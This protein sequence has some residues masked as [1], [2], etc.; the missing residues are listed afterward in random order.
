[1]SQDKALDG[2]FTALQ[3]RHGKAIS[4][5]KE[6]EAV[7][8]GDYVSEIVPEKWAD[9]GLEPTVMPTASDIIHNAVDHILTSPR[10]KV[11]MRP[12]NKNRETER[13]IAENK[14]YFLQHCWDM[15]AVQDGDV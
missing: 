7:I 4:A 10:M 6:D 1:M 13:Q 11:P 3:T 15:F 2:R 9:E 8:H 5:F 12:V 14:R